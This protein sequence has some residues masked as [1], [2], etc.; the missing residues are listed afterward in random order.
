MGAAQFCEDP[1]GAASRACAVVKKAASEI[2]EL[3]LKWAVIPIAARQLA[4]YTVPKILPIVAPSVP[5]VAL[6]V[7]LV[8][9]PLAVIAAHKAIVHADDF[10]IP[11]IK[12]TDF[13]ALY[14]GAEEKISKFRNA[15]NRLRIMLDPIQLVFA[16][17]A[18]NAQNRLHRV[19]NRNSAQYMKYPI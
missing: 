12:E 8:A 13:A 16:Q 7:P 1:K 9:G 4:A 19:F 15:Q 17:T 14:E 18:R 3:A 6:V 11:I 5:G 10:F 2:P